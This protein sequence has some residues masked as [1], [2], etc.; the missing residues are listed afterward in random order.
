MVR[1]SDSSIFIEFS[2]TSEI[3]IGMQVWLELH[4]QG[5]LK[6]AKVTWR[7]VWKPW[8]IG[9]WRY[10]TIFCVSG[11]YLHLLFHHKLDDDFSIEK[12]TIHGRHAWHIVLY[13]V[14]NWDTCFMVCIFC[15]NLGDRPT[16]TKV[17]GEETKK[18]RARCRVTWLPNGVR[19][20]RGV[21]SWTL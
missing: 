10:G 7:A 14:K 6:R 20:R 13:R 19:H 2:L 3:E 4:H 12:Q 15:I 16:C 9:D 1:R 21:G 8:L 17:T 5:G 18:K 11:I